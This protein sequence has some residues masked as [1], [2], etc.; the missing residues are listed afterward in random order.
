MVFDKAMDAEARE[1]RK[2]ALTE[3]IA[4]LEAQ[5]KEADA[6]EKARIAGLIDSKRTELEDLQTAGD[7]GEPAPES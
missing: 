2:T 7:A 4:A 1:G 5:A 6:D 3:E